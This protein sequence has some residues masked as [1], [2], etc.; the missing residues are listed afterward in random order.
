[1]AYWDE[2][3]KGAQI[4][5]LLAYCGIDY[6]HEMLVRGP[7]PDFHKDD[8]KEK[9]AEIRHLFDFPNVPYLVDERSGISLTESKS[10]MKYLAMT[11]DSSLLGRDAEEVGVCDMISRVHDD[12]YN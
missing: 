5:N 7:A 4:F 8:W 2:R 12:W 3:A 6:E 9:R 10:I 1:M 11:H